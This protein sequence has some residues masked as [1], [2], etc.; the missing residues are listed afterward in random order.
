MVDVPLDD[1]HASVLGEMGHHG[2]RRPISSDSPH[3][4]AKF[5]GRRTPIVRYDLAI[6]TDKG[7]AIFF[8]EAVSSRRLR[9]PPTVREP[10]LDGQ[11]TYATP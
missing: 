4:V 3:L 1:E 7:F 2:W 6:W 8:D 5:E 9:N 10:S 11:S